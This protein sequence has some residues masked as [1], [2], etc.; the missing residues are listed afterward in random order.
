MTDMSYCNL[1]T[2]E[3]VF[4]TV[5]NLENTLLADYRHTVFY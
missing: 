4:S 3:V 1:G 5:Y 2:V